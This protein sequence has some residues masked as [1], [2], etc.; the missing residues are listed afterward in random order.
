MIASYKPATRQL[1]A[2]YTDGSC[3]LYRLNEP[4][5]PNLMPYELRKFLANFPVDEQSPQTCSRLTADTYF[6]HGGNI[7]HWASWLRSAL[8]P[9]D[10][11]YY[12]EDYDTGPLLRFSSQ[13]P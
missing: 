5:A 12:E 10:L 1:Q 11:T 8:L 6:R 7:F 3:L 13:A 9:L 2:S 4:P